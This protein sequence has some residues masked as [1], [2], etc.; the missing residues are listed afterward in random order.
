MLTPGVHGV[1]VNGGGAIGADE[2]LHPPGPVDSRGAW[3]LLLGVALPMRSERSARRQ[4]ERRAR[5][6]EVTNHTYAL[7]RSLRVSGGDTRC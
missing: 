5:F 7:R 6:G 2:I 1:D 4:R 3:M